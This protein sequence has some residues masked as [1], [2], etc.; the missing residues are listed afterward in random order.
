MSRLNERLIETMVDYARRPEPPPPSYSIV[1]PLRA[2]LRFLD[3]HSRRRLADLPFL[4]VDLKFGDE[5]TWTRLLRTPAAPRST[6]RSPPGRRSAADVRAL[7]LARGVTVFA[8]HIVQGQPEDAAIHLGVTEPVAALLRGADLLDLDRAAI[9]VADQ[10]GP[11][12]SDRPAAW[13]Y[14]LKHA[15][16]PTASATQQT[17]YALQL[18]G[19]DLGAFD[20][21]GR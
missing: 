14:L 10:C 6:P 2:T 7:A 4:L 12:W 18:L 9:R 1:T 11:R 19:G 20:K 16:Q 8:W 5:Y 17:V 13:Q 15:A 21:L 3:A